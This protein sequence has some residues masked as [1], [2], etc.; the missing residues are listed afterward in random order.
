M[1]AKGGFQKLKKLSF[2]RHLM[3]NKIFHHFEGPPGK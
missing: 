2:F 1:N 3:E